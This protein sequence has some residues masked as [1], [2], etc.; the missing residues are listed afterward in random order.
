M[1]NRKLTKKK[2]AQKYLDRLQPKGVQD[3]FNDYFTNLKT[4]EL[5]GDLET[6][7][8]DTFRLRIGDYRAVFEVEDYESP[9]EQGYTGEI[10]I[11]KI[12]PRGGVYKGAKGK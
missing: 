5:S 11:L 6:I 3:R 4:S 7:D 2:Q 8:D 12:G 10:I 9:D 1:I